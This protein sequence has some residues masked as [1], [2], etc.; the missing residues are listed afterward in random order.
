LETI[1]GRVKEVLEKDENTVFAYIF[2]SYVA[3]KH[4]KRSDIDIAVYTRRPMKWKEL[5]RLTLKLEDSLGT[6]VDVIDLRT[7]PPLLAYEVVSKG[8]V[9]VERDREER[10]SFENRVL[11]EYLDL[12]PRLER[13]YTEILS[14]KRQ[15]P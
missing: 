15:H 4:G 3:G 1:A 11:K 8:V 5:V 9:V 13:Y 6:R 14:K 7:A 12:K 10:I 2:G